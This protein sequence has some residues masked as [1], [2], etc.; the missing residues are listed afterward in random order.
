MKKTLSMVAILLAV[1]GFLYS[2]VHIFGTGIKY[3]EYSGL[4]SNVKKLTEEKTKKTSELAALTKKNADV[5]AEYEKLRAEK[6]I[7][8]VYLTFDDGPS[9]HTDQILEILKKNNIKATF[10]VIG[11]GKN[12]KDY[13]KITDQGHAIGL[14]SFTHE[15]K[16]VYANE[17]S[18]FK[19][20][21]QLRD[22][23]KS[24]TG[25]DVKIIRFP[26]GSS[27]AIASKA[28]KTAI[29]NRLT[30]EGF[31]YFDWN[32]DSTD[33]SGNNVPVAK[34]VKYGVCTTHPDI[35]VL[36]HD[37]NAKKT[38][39]QALQQIIDGYRKAGYTFETLDVN[40]PRIQHVKQPE[41]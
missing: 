5:K 6:K 17:D 12:F 22:A 27:N 40:S 30:R 29:I 19:E 7:K 32:C 36:M 25:Q 34:L 21:Y 20:F 41:M 4:K 11:I 39:V 37:T 1:L 2:A 35:N 13:K 33:A 38:T 3:F 8:T 23:I 15:Y 16:K 9:G 24:T 28:L 14:H 18:F 10:F 31:V 26:G